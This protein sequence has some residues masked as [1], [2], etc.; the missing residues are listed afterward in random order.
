MKTIVERLRQHAQSQ[1]DAVA[2]RFLSDMSTEPQVLSY[3][4]LWDEAQRLA[5]FLQERGPAGSRA[6]LLFPPGL[7]YVRA[8]FACLM[9]RWVAVP[10]YLPRRGIKQERIDK[11]A[12]S[13]DARLALTTRAELDW[14]SSPETI[15]PLASR[16]QFHAVDQDLLAGAGPVTQAGPALTDLAF[17]QYTSGSTGMPKGVMISHANIMGNVEHLSLMSTGNP[18]DRFVNWLP[19]FHDLGLVT[20]V[21]WPAAMGAESTLMAPA[22]FVRDPE[23]WLR[24]ITEY[25]GTMCGAPNFAYQLCV[26]K[27][28]PERLAGL[29]LSSWRVAYNAAEPVRASTLEQFAR[30]FAASGFRSTAFY[31]SYGMAEATVFISGGDA[32]AEPVTQCADRFALADRQLSLL[33]PDSP[34]ATQIVACGAALG[35]HDL[36]IVDPDSR[37]ALPEGQVGEIWFAGPSVAGGYWEMPELSLATFGQAIVDEPDNAHRYLRTGDLGVMHQG[38]VYITGRI[39]DLV[40]VHG[41]NLYPQDIELSAARAHEAVR[42]GHVAAFAQAGEEGEQLVVVAEIERA[43]FRSMD[44]QAVIDA[45]RSAVM[46]QYEAVVNRVVLVRP[47]KVP[48][49]S[50]GKIQR[51]QARAML[52]DGTLEILADTGVLHEPAVSGRAPDSATERALAAIWC[53][54]LNRSQVSAQDHF[55]A[56][57]GDSLS[58]AEVVAAI[59]RQ[60]GL[61]DLQVAQLFETPRLEDMARWIDARQ[62]ARPAV[63][64][65]PKRT[66]TV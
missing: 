41:R 6:L 21:L 59:G 53:A 42:E 8:F 63:Q 10:L 1:P 29:D 32:A 30:H 58:A 44:A 43:H 36:R 22:A 24:A 51:R 7:D 48:M 33:P 50:S 39:K 38:Q 27:I 62:Q 20:T 19:L 3:A 31:P 16:L 28:R 26:D 4:G 47:Y 15:G 18:A 5:G 9:A 49:T 60:Y 55:L 35:P 17:L 2:F 46:E 64:A 25:R 61:P 13:C 37:K 45:I 12:Q 66:V 34:R 57:G 52:Q 23:M 54:A 56:L 65:A 11:V 14:L 40:I